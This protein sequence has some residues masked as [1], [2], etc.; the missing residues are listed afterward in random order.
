[1]CIGIPMKITAYQGE[2]AVCE[3]DGEQRL[4][5]MMLVG[6]QDIGVWVLVFLDTAREIVSEDLA[7]QIADALQAVR[8]AM[9]GETRFDHLFADLLDRTPQLPPFLTQ[10]TE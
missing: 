4:I 9:S 7:A 3:C 1:M 5:D 6:K 2:W 10:G 8:L